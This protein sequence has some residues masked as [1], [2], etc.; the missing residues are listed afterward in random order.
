MGQ[1]LG[2]IVIEGLLFFLLLFL[3]SISLD[4]VGGHLYFISKINDFIFGV[5]KFYVGFPEILYRLC[6]LPSDNRVNGRFP[7]DFIE[8]NVK[9][10]DG[11]A[12]LIQD[13]VVEVISKDDNV[14][15]YSLGTLEVIP[16]LLTEVFI[17]CF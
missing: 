9:P 14:E 10:E 17:N 2:S 8:V 3:A 13:D 4:L 12:D 5:D 16:V 15:G 6:P 11:G 1:H 7:G